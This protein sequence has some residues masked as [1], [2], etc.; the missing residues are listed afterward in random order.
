MRLRNLSSNTF[1]SSKLVLI[2]FLFNSVG[3]RVSCLH[4]I[5]YQ[6]NVGIHLEACSLFHFAVD[7]GITIHR[8]QEVLVLQRLQYSSKRA[9]ISLH[10]GRHDWNGLH[11]ALQSVYQRSLPE[12]QTL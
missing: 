1:L 6:Q 9:S 11:Q 5:F 3:F 7:F 12:I 4:F 2:Y 8:K 10:L